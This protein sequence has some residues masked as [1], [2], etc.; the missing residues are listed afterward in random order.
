MSVPLLYLVLGCRGS[1]QFLAVA[2]LIEF[3]T[4]KEDKSLVL[5]SG[6]DLA[7]GAEAFEAPRRAASLERYDWTESGFSTGAIGDA[8][9]VFLVSDGVSDPSDFVEA[10]HQWL[11][12]SGCELAR[13]ITVLHCDLAARRR[14]AMDWFECC[15]HFSDVVLLSKREKVSNRQMKDFLSYYDEQCYPCH[16]EY[17][18]KGRVSNPSLVLNP[19]PRRISRIFDA[20]EIFDDDEEDE[21]EEE[22]LAGD[23]ARDPFLKRIAGGR[24][25]RPLPR[26]QDFLQA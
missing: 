14:V 7:E 9:Y 2:D 3:G 20:Q 25:E 19:Q 1:D 26:I 11:P 15:I 6:A 17:L 10:F 4:D 16:F 18:K 13:V 8:D 5:V 24:R 22:Q 21:I 23:A 12:E